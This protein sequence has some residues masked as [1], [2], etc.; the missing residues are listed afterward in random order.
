[1]TRPPETEYDVLIAGGGPAG[2]SLAIRL[3]T[4][5]LRV[6]LA[7]QKR[8]PREK[9]CGEFISPECLAHFSALGVMDQMLEPAGS[10]LTATVFYSQGGRGTTIPSSW[11]GQDNI[12][13]LG[14]SRAEM[15]LR[16]FERAREVGAEVAAETVIAGLLLE[17]GVVRGARLV[18]RG[19]ERQVRASL[20]IDATGRGRALARLAE[21]NQHDAPTRPP[22]AHF[23]AFKAHLTDARIDP[24]HCEIYVYRGGYGGVNAIEHGLFN[25][26]FIVRTD[27]VR[28]FGHDA[29][30]IVREVVMRNRRA[31]V[32]LA[33]AKPITPWLAVALPWYGARELAPAPGLLTVGDAA[34]FIDPFTGSGMLMALESSK[35]AAEV[36]TN[37]FAAGTN[38][39]ATA[40]PYRRAYQTSFRHRLRVSGW[41]RRAAFVPGAADLTVRAV[42]ISSLLR[43]RLAR[44]TRGAGSLG[45]AAG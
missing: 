35:V 37:F 18:S 28:K 30:R 39:V 10:R 22:R 25:H 15:D 21:R 3:A 44:S 7:E 41:L 32:T 1:M 20:T 13:A 14:L 12:D 29:E 19:I 9:L 31:A 24:E 8:F 40:S 38:L 17:A 2:S 11:F 5:G 33:V 23:V 43:R 4:A 6:L 36:V 26:C 42:G 16:L 27:L 45:N 34:A